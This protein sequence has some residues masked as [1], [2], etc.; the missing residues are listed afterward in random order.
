M[1]RGRF[2]V[3]GLGSSHSKGG[4][5]GVSGVLCLVIARGAGH[6]FTLGSTVAGLRAR[7]ERLAVREGRPPSRSRLCVAFE[8]FVAPVD[9][10]VGALRVVLEAVPAALIPAAVRPSDALQHCRK[11]GEG[12]GRG[13]SQE[14]RI[15]VGELLTFVSDCV[16]LLCAHA[17]MAREDERSSLA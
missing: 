3:H 16:V 17:H 1:R 7:D 10:Y 15:S 13:G 6:H 4:R 5:L 14:R 11:R 9:E 12:E 8:G 2:R